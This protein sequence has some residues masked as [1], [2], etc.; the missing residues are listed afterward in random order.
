[1]SMNKRVFTM[2]MMIALLMAIFVPKAWGQQAEDPWDGET[3]TEVTPEGDIYKITT[4][5]ELA[6]VASQQSD[7]FINQTI[8][9]EKDIDLGEKEWTPIPSFKGTFD[10]QGHTIRGLNINI[11][12]SKSD[13]GGDV[14]AGLF[15]SLSGTVTQLG[16]IGVV[17]VTT[18][19]TNVYLQEG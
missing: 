9:L 16:V 2:M 10:G 17:N 7:V 3:K 8:Q 6:W 19:I 1:M 12:L 5:A 15:T 13:L 11:N 14:S 18:V 4:G